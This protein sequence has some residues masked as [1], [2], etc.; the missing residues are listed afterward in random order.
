MQ[1]KQSCE[2]EM[3]GSA[4]PLPVFPSILNSQEN[5]HA[6]FIVITEYFPYRR[7]LTHLYM[8]FF[9]AFSDRDWEPLSL[10]LRLIL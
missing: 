10:F 9:S 3:N 5:N 6:D 7:T 1:E 8:L 2:I 4:S